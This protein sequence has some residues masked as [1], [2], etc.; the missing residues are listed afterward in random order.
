MNTMSMN[1]LP[2][3]LLLIQLHGFGVEAHKGSRQ[4]VVSLNVAA[5][6][7]HSQEAAAAI[8]AEEE[9]T[10]MELADTMR[11][12]G[13]YAEQ[14]FNAT[15]AAVPGSIPSDKPW[16]AR[17]S[18][19]VFGEGWAWKYLAALFV[20]SALALLSNSP[21]QNEAVK[22]GKPATTTATATTV[23]PEKEDKISKKKSK[24]DYGSEEDDRSTCAGSSTV[25]SPETTVM[26]P[27]MPSP[28]GGGGATVQ[29]EVMAM[30]SPTAWRPRSKQSQEEKVVG[31]IK[32][33]LNKLTREK[34]DA[35]SK[36]LFALISERQ[37]VECVAR[38]V[39]DKATTQ[40]TFIEMYADLCAELES[41]AKAGV[42]KN[43]ENFKRVLLDQC[44]R[45]FEL[46]LKRPAGLDD[47]TGDEHMEE[48]V[49]YKTRM[50]GNMKFVGALLRRKML[51][52][53]IIFLCTDELLRLRSEET[54]E[55]VCAFLG[56]VCPAFDT[57]EWPEG[58]LKF[59]VIFDVLNRMAL[60]VE[61]G[62]VSTRVSCL[63]RD[64]LDKKKSSWGR[65]PVPSR[66]SPARAP[67]AIR[68]SEEQTSSS[69]VAPW[70]RG[71]ASPKEAA[72]TPSSRSDENC[73][74][75]PANRR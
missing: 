63:I 49:K 24:D 6:A 65:I 50:L 7:S 67:E 18:A 40:H 47:L 9:T 8:Q 31:E 34:Y 23:K 58:S 22:K 13:A 72:K 33:I 39:F 57:P 27:P 25:S 29:P 11:S 41:G 74:R 75:S 54:L 2:L 21:H 4:N 14:E 26:T 45:S 69:S 56:A 64:L 1:A 3:L 10:G 70:R 52:P 16:T 59:C 44:Q 73:W 61:K 35:L 42:F 12:K 38:E 28:S 55:T 68:T 37:H 62:V 43:G 36:Q 30:P 66:T 51:S 53:K 60:S 5:D 17:F 32:S 15:K 19:E 20:G 46:Y 71:S 48:L